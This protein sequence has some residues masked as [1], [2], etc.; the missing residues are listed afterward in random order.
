[1]EQILLAYSL[2]KETFT[3][4]M[5]LYN[6]MKAIVCSPNEDTDFLDLIAGVLQGDILAPY[7]S[8]IGR[9][10]VPQMPIDLMIKRHR[11]YLVLNEHTPII[12]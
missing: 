1:M 2:P 8:I 4:L 12:F 3:F 9:N 6:N 5:M 7:M 10:Y 11:D